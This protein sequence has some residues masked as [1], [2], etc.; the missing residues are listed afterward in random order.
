MKIEEIRLELLYKHDNLI[1]S[2]EK[3]Q[4]VEALQLCNPCDPEKIMKSS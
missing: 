2:L 1:I 4:H 3:G